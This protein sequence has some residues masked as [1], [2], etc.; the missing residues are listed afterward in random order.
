[1]TV[2]YHAASKSN[3]D[4]AQMT[5]GAMLTLA[6]MGLGLIVAGSVTVIELTTIGDHATLKE[7]EK[8]EIL[9]EASK[10]RRLT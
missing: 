3:S 9:Y 7:P 10:F 6:L 4:E 1:M 2:E 5:T 8:A